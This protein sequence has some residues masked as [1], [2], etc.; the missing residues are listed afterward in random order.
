MDSRLVRDR[1][2]G[3][4]RRKRRRFYL[5]REVEWESDG[6]LF[7]GTLSD[8][9]EDGCFI[10]SGGEVA[11]GQRIR[12]HLPIDESRALAIAG[13]VVNHAYEIGFGVRF[14]QLGDSE[15]GLIKRMFNFG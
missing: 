12:I 5:T 7:N 1:R 2:Q 8:I 10:L 4:D 13:E 15:I 3:T 6:R 14:R 11:N 9:S